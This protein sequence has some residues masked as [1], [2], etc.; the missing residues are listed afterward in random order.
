MFLCGQLQT[1]F[2]NDWT[3]PASLENFISR[4]SVFPELHDCIAERAN[5]MSPK[6]WI[7]QPRADGSFRLATEVVNLGVFVKKEFMEPRMHGSWMRRTE[8]RHAY[9]VALGI[10]VRVRDWRAA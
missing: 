5:H 10:G 9:E 6:V 7:G 3:F 1:A 2:D 4:P 8:H